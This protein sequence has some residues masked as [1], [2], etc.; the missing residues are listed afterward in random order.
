MLQVKALSAA[1]AIAAQYDTSQLLLAQAFG[2]SITQQVAP[3][4]TA[5]VAAAAMAAAGAKQKRGFAAAN[6][7]R[8]N[9]GDG[10]D[11]GRAPSAAADGGSGAGVAGKKGAQVGELALSTGSTTTSSS[12]SGGVDAGISSKQQQQQGQGQGQYNG[13]PRCSST[14]GFSMAGGIGSSGSNAL[15]AL[16]ADRVSPVRQRLL[17][18]VGE[19]RDRKG[20][21][22]LRM[23]WPLVRLGEWLGGWGKGGGVRPAALHTA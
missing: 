21:E 7:L 23:S 19:Q 15:A 16:L 20:L 12:L 13:R 1:P 6:T 10:G 9:A 8:G 3:G 5:A 17:K 11:A 4:I 22:P 2:C 14:G 18:A